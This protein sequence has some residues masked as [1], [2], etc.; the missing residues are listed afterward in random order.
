MSHPTTATAHPRLELRFG[1]AVRTVREQQGFTQERLAEAAKLNRSYL[2]EIERGLVTP[3][4]VTISKIAEALG[5]AASVLIGHSET[6][7]A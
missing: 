6:P 7:S 4:L 5:M 1:N 2:G 3:S